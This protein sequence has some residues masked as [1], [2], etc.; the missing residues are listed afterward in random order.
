[1]AR[2]TGGPNRFLALF[3]LG[4]NIEPEYYLPRAVQEL[5]QIAGSV[6]CSSVWQSRAVGSEPQPDY[7]NAV[8]ALQT[9]WSIEKWCQEILPHV[10]TQLG[11]V[12]DPGNKNAPRTI[13]IDPVLFGNQVHIIGHRLIPAPELVERWFVA[14]PAAEVAPYLQ[15]PVDGR[16]LCKIAHDLWSCINETPRTRP[17][18]RLS[19]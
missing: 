1:M 11:R 16:T 12:R 6:R 5:V 13:D 10:E 18:V 14:V 4:S 19:L 15:H 9:D 2:A 17:D 8:V 7:L 3:C